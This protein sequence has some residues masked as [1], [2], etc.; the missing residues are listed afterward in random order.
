MGDAPPQATDF[1]AATPADTRCG[2]RIAPTYGLRINAAMPI[3][4]KR[5]Y[6]PPSPDDGYRV[7]VDRVW[8]RG[9]TRERAAL[10]EWARE[11][12]PSDALRR[13]FGH[14]P[15]RFDEFSRRYRGE[16]AAHPDALRGLRRRARTATL[17]IVFSA[18]DTAHT[19]AAVLSQ[20]LRRGLR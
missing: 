12:A 3:R 5:I 4:L 16:L 15:E 9:V 11:L 7:L 10:D 2:Y 6:E 20:V 13:W 18:R 8:P 1:R 14:A 17:T 19:N